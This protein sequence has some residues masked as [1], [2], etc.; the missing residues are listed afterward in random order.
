MPE[1]PTTIAFYLPQFHPTP[2]NDSW[3]GAGFTEWSNVV[4]ARPLF[5]GHYQPH[6]P[7]DFG[8]YDLRVPAVREAQ[9][10]AARAHGI[11][12]FC[13]Y[14]YWFEGH[15]PLRSVLDDVLRHGSPVIPFCLAWANENWSRHWDAS[16]HEVLLRQRY[17]REDDDEHA[18]FLLR[19][20]L[21]PDYLR[22]AGRPVLFIYRI[23]AMPESVATLARWR[24]IWRAG[25][26]DEVHIVKFDTH[27]DDT[28]PAGHGADAAA[29]FL[30]HNMGNYVTP[31][32]IP[33][34]HPDNLVF[35]YEDVVHAYL[36][37]EP[38][39]WRRYEC[40]APNWDNSPRRGDGKSCILHG[41]TPELYEAWL[42]GAHRRAPGDGLVLINAWNEWAE[43]AH[44]EPD[45]RHGAAYLR[46]TA[47]A[48]GLT[49]PARVH[50]LAPAPE[51]ERPVV[52]D[53]FAEL[54]LDVLAAHTTTQRR[55]SRLE[56]TLERQIEFARGDADA[57]I[58]RL[59]DE[60]ASLFRENERLRAQ[61]AEVNERTGAA[62]A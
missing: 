19:A 34:A 13:F 39:P 37:A 9:A 35:D 11:D 17:S 58:S 25:G 30:P 62:H 24:D 16:D 47:R 48:L 2:E 52:R 3:Y 45:V 27:G 38:A 46:A 20:M 10:R 43:G 12:A 31:T 32:R 14:H 42:S 41:S 44:L 60:A 29:Q 40:V 6:L 59:R 18:H 22:V 36:G 57:E 5:A 15:R 4:Q 23:Q 28:D 33:A 1:R 55:L 26:L 61:L 51:T 21:H 8:F 49:P 56:G 54:Y 50:E 53:R 7:S